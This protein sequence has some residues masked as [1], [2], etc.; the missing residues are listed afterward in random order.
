[1]DL[2]IYITIRHKLPGFRN[3]LET[4]FCPLKGY[5]LLMMFGSRQFPLRPAAPLIAVVGADGSGKSTVG[6]ALLAWMS[7]QYPTRLCHL[8]KQTGNWGRWI[9]RIPVLGK[10]VDQKIVRKSSSVRTEKGS[11]AFTSIVI[12][13]LS[14]RRLARFLKMRFWR[15]RGYAIVTDRYP[16]ASIPGPM[17]GPGLVARQP[18]SWMA[19]WLTRIEQKIYDWMA[20]YPPDLVIRLHVDLPTA[21]IRKPDHRPASLERKIN[22]VPLLIFPGSPVLDLNSVDPLESILEQA[23][24]AIAPILRKA[25]PEHRISAS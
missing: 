23:K 1:M 4:V 20:D 5:V 25:S 11:G 17:D 15:I 7:E 8:G 21:L 18:R 22:D 3:R 9:A 16:Q 2:E 6:S 14:M 24:I 13:T 12:F 10:R 19:R